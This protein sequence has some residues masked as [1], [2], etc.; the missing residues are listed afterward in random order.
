MVLSL[1]VQSTGILNLVPSTVFKIFISTIK[2]HMNKQHWNSIILSGNISDDQI[3]EWI[4]NSYRFVIENLP[5]S[6]RS[7][8]NNTI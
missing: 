1:K 8:I 7:D 3:K 6:K 5:K 2:N 4:D